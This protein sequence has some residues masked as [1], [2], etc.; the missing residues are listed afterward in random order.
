ML[1]S[2]KDLKP[3]LTKVSSTS[4]NFTSIQYVCDN[5]HVSFWFD[6]VSYISSSVLY[7]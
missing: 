5:T 7:C 6:G 1:E 4:Y 3:S 2:L